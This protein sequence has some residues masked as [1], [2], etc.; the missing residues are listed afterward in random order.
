[1]LLVTMYRSYSK[2]RSPSDVE[3]SWWG[4]WLVSLLIENRCFVKKQEQLNGDSDTVETAAI[5]ESNAAV[6]FML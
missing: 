6:I 5:Y 4:G 3:C 2:S 1:M